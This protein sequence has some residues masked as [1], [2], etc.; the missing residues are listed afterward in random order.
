VSFTSQSSVLSPRL[1]L[2]VLLCAAAR[3]DTVA[4]TSGFTYPNVHIDRIEDG[5]IYFVL[6]GDLREK[7]VTDVVTFS[8]DDENDFNTAEA[9]YQSHDYATAAVGYSNAIVGADKKWLRSWIAPRLLDAANHSGRFDLAV[10]GWIRMV[11]DDSATAAGLRPALPGGFSEGLDAAAIELHD[12]TASSHGEA[13]RLILGLLLDVETARKD[14]AAANAAAQALAATTP[15]DGGTAA[16]GSAEQEMR[17]AL[18]RTA[19]YDKKFDQTVSLIDESASILTDPANQAEALFLRAGA[20]EGIAAAANTPSD[21]KDAAL[22]YL[23]V[24]VHF[25]DG[26]ASAHSAAALMKAAEIEAD[27]LGDAPAAATLY[28]KVVSEYQDSTAARQAAAQ[29][30]GLEPK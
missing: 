7:P 20:L 5:N 3:A 13:K 6:N 22:A 2:L 8:I 14:G 16:V 29:L 15:G 11:N 18:A 1:F 28:Q 25:R 21:W 19:L 26:P 4:F 10:A 12:A 27:H 17:L 24:Y 23:R 30:K 9:A